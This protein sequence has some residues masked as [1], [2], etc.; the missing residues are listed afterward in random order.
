MINSSV[1]HLHLRLLFVTRVSTVGLTFY[2]LEIE[3]S[4]T[5][6]LKGWHVWVVTAVFVQWLL[7]C[8]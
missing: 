5:T 8:C 2:E 1:N 7:T 3:M 4:E 6:L